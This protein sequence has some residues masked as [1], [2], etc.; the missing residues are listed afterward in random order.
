MSFHSIFIQS[1]TLAGALFLFA[2]LQAQPVSERKICVG[3]VCMSVVD[4]GDAG[5]PADTQTGL[6]SVAQAFA[7]S[8]YEVTL[9]QYVRFLNAVATRPYAL[10]PNKQEAV[11]ELWLPEMK[12]THDYVS[13]DGLIGRTGLGTAESP[14]V[15]QEVPDSTWGALSGKRGML[16]ISWFSAARFANWMHNGATAEA[17][18]ETGA[19]NLHG[20][21]TGAISRNPDAKWWIPS[22]NE[23]YKAAFYDPTRP[24]HQPYWNYPTRSD[25]LPDRGPIPGGSNSANFNGAQPEGQHI[26]PV[27]TYKKSISFY[28]TYD[29]A[30][31]LWE[32]T[33]TS[34]NN[35]DGQPSTMGLM[36]GSWSLGQINVS[37]HGGRDYLPQ[38]NDDDTGFRLATRNV[39]ETVLV[40]AAG[41][42][43]DPITG[44]GAVDTSFR[45]SKSEVT[46]E[47][48]VV[49]LNAVAAVPK[50]HVISNLWVSEMMSDR[51]D[52]GPLIERTGSGT[53]TAPYRYHVASSSLWGPHAGKRPVAWVTWFDAAR[54]ANWLHNGG[55]TDPNAQVDTETG[56]YT[57]KNYQTTG[58]IARNPDA[59]WWIPSENEWYKAAYFDPKKSGGAGYW[60]YPT[61]SDLPPRDVRL[62]IQE[63]HKLVPPPAPAANFNE[64]YVQLKR[65]NGGTLTPVCAYSSHDT[66]LD[67]R[68]PWGTCDQ[69]GSLWEWTEGTDGQQNKIVRGGSWGPGLTPPLKS[70]RRDYGLMGANDFYRDDDTG[71]RLATKP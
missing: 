21:R 54:F 71:F 61:R 17:D 66:R 9:E 31:L 45:I 7:I 15:F 22:Q 40:G 28:G 38:Y 37:K 20:A 60:N 55:N 43:A 18:T 4:V 62:N 67:S 10:A 49:F 27:G 2:P 36:G 6:G 70:K 63:Q 57:F 46:I 16:N 56:A 69:A 33:D 12:E 3:L 5:N 42:P 59:R 58:T 68:G 24:G 64:I 29:Q 34:Y 44:Y 32:W 50:N 35:H 52:P 30:G 8:Q 41:N 51:E 1:L 53:T 19:Y 13:K 14:F 26:T 11:L 47:Q 39:I 23:W 48:Y 65:K 25:V